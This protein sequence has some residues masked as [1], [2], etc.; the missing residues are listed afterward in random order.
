MLGKL[1]ILTT[2]MYSHFN[3]RRWWG[4]KHSGLDQFN[5]LSRGRR[6]Y[7]Q[8][9][10]SPALSAPNSPYFRG[11]CGPR[12]SR[13]PR[14]AVSCG[15]GQQGT[16]AVLAAKRYNLCRYSSGLQYATRRDLQPRH[17]GDGPR[18]DQSDHNYDP[19]G[20]HYYPS[21]GPRWIR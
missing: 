21:L 10:T 19:D 17:H 12:R 9:V 1:L 20:G 15:W 5:P 6:G 8:S 13:G 18:N 11:Q 3:G 16:A 4:Y 14:R 7:Y 2:L